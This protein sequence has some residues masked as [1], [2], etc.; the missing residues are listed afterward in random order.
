MCEGKI[1]FSHFPL[2]CCFSSRERTFLRLLQKFFTEIFTIF[3]SRQLSVKIVAADVEKL[4]IAWLT[5]SLKFDKCRG[6]VVKKVSVDWCPTCLQPRF[7][8]CRAKFRKRKT[9]KWKVGKV[10]NKKIFIRLQPTPKSNARVP[11]WKFDESI[12]SYLGKAETS[13]S[14]DHYRTFKSFK[15][16]S[17]VLCW[18]LKF[19]SND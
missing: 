8:S 14:V 7:A 12:E 13:P 18:S 16:F 3:S 6:S 17:Q 11:M 10:R 2:C 4:F 19:S 9:Q 5:E 1:S 15:T